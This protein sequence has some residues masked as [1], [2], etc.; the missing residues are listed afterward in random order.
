VVGVAADLTLAPRETEIV[1]G[2]LKRRS[3]DLRRGLIRL[4]ARNPQEAEASAA[5][6]LAT[7]NTEQ[8]QAE[9]QLLLETGGTPPGGFR[10]GNTAEETL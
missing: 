10:P 9:L 5:R 8:R 2:L 6:L 1:H 7:R 4:L 3:A